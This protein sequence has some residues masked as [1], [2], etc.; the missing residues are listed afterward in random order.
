[1]A[2]KLKK[3]YEFVGTVKSAEGFFDKKV[4]GKTVKGT[5]VVIGTQDDLGVTIRR[6][7]RVSAW[8]TEFPKVWTTK[9]L[10]IWTGFPCSD[11]QGVDYPYVAKSFD[12]SDVVDTP[13]GRFSLTLKIEPWTKFTDI[14][15]VGSPK[16]WPFGYLLRNVTVEG[17]AELVKSESVPQEPKKV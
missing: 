1:M 4:I 6:V 16:F 14:R 17:A 13:T 15:A 8:L 11:L 10:K 12:V 9:F 7:I 3:I 2:A 5:I